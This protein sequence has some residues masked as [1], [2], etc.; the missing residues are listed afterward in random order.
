MLEQHEPVALHAWTGAPCLLRVRLCR[1]G[2]DELH[3]VQTL[4]SCT[5]S[6]GRKGKCTKAQRGV[7]ACLQP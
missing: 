3:V 2:G 6:R 4:L 5:A 1:R 7:R